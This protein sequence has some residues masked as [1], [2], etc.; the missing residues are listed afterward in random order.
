MSYRMLFSW[1][2]RRT[3]A[4]KIHHLTIRLLATLS[5]LPVV[6]RILHAW[7]APRDEALRVRAFGVHFPSPFGL[8][9]GFDK[10]AECVAGAGRARLR[11]RRG[12]HDHRARP[13][14]QRPA[15][16]VPPGP[17]PRDHQPDGLQQRGRQSGGPPVEA[18]PRRARG[19]RREHRQD[20]GRP[21]GGGDPRLRRQRQDPRRAGR[22]P[23]RERLLAQH[24]RPAQPPGRRPAAPAADGEVKDGRGAHP[25]AGED[26]P[27]P[28]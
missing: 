27:R 20:Q 23:G 3:D 24:P 10:N 7:L 2:L 5:V 17:R 21:G 12:R 11:P 9:A 6:K 14:R 19:R 16:A 8:A 26:R 22:L 28:G 1:V 18:G 13:A 15:P 25:A 4:E